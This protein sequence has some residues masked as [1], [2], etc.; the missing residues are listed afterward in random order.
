MLSNSGPNNF[1]FE[2]VLWDMDGTLLDSEPIWIEEEAKL[3][4]SLGVNWNEED[5]RICLGGPMHRVDLYMRNRSGNRHKP[6]ELSGLLIERM[7]ARLN[8]SVNFTPGAESLLNELHQMGIPMALVTASTR[9]IVTAALSSIGSH[10]FL[11]TISANDVRET[12]PHPEGYLTA[13]SHL[14]VSIKRSLIIEDSLTGMSAAIDSGAYVLGIPHFY[15]LPTGEKV[16]HVKSLERIDA[17]ALTNLFQ[18]IILV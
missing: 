16:R 2:A 14:N 6:L 17:Q 11:R 15:D 8:E 1:P 3:M 9:E 4:E 12:K 7:V 10:Y 13:S 5:A 18:E